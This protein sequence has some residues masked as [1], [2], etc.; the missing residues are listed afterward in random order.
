LRPSLG[1]LSRAD[2]DLVLGRYHPGATTRSVAEV[3]GRSVPGTRKALHR[4]RAALSAGVRRT[5]SRE[6][7]E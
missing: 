7:D 2:R 6:G 4:I 1:K 5:P 3:L